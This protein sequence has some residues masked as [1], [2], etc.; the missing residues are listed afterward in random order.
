MYE[1]FDFRFK[2][3]S[4]VHLALLMLRKQTQF[5]FFMHVLHVDLNG[6]TVKTQHSL[7]L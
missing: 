6:V 5:D 2:I 4:L 1:L 7:E 3:K